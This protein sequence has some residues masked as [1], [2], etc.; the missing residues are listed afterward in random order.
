MELPTETVITPTQL[1]K[2]I[3]NS[4]SHVKHLLDVAF[5]IPYQW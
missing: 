3:I 4:K 1:I 5:M 2:V